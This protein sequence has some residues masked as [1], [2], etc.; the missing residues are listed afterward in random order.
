MFSGEVIVSKILAAS[1]VSG[2]SGDILAELPQM[3]GDIH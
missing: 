3:R 2:R 1:P